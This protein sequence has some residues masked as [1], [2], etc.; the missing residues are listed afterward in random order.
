MT[1][2]QFQDLRGA[3][4]MIIPEERKDISKE[5][6]KVLN[7]IERILISI[8]SK[9]TEIPK[10]C[11]EVRLYASFIILDFKLNDVFAIRYSPNNIYV[12][13]QIRT[14]LDKKYGDLIGKLEVGQEISIFAA[15]YIKN[16]ALL[17]ENFKR[18]LDMTDKEFDLWFKL[19]Y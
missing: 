6:I 5:T 17:P 1:S 16:I 11:F 7:H 13:S 3:I 9:E 12:P 2:K 19:E 15:S 10:N 8:V 14:E 4:T 18:T